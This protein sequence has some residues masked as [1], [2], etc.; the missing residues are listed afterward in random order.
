MEKGHK[1]NENIL[2]TINTRMELLEHILDESNQLIEVTSKDTH[3]I[4]Y[5]NKNF[6]ELIGEGNKDWHNK[7]CYKYINGHDELCG[8]CPFDKLEGKTELETEVSRDDCIYQVKIKEINWLGCDAFIMYATDITV[9]KR[10]QEIFE[11][12]MRML[13]ESIPD[14][15][16][17]FH[18]NVTKDKWISSLGASKYVD[19]LQ[20][21]PD[22]NTTVKS[23]ADYIPDKDSREEFIQLFSKENMRQMYNNG[24]PQ[25]VKEVRSFY[26]DG[27]IKWARMTARLLM[28]PKTAELECILYGMDISDEKNFQEKIELEKR[29]KNVILEKS[30]LDMLT[31]LY[32]KMAF[33]QILKDYIN[34]EKKEPYAVIFLDI[35]HFKDVNDT[36][37]HI[38]GD[39]LIIRAGNAL[40][41][42]FDGEDVVSRFG[43]DEFCVLAK[44]ISK[45]TLE[46]KLHHVLERFNRNIVEDKKSVKI[47]ASIG[48][49]LC[50]KFLKDEAESL[51]Q[52]AD[53][54]LYKSKREGRNR[55]TLVSN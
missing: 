36:F 33:L 31:G 55:Y 11:T 40:K 22:I 29:E 2:E 45:K 6:R 16:G 32:S 47:S 4:L 51:I 13:I 7:E 43:G 49:I 26:D 10:A 48:V 3:K 18:F 27:S 39:R 35:D 41:E 46:L 19:K 38:S 42:I 25:L 15:Q 5:V 30:K 50:H 21:M 54:A 37:G 9:I 34:A 28:N 44:G 23:I 53:E 17:I 24:V 1:K 12:Q 52:R 20:N 8:F 14:A